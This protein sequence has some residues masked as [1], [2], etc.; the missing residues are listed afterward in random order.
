MRGWLGIRADDSMWCGQRGTVGNAK[1]PTIS[2]ATQRLIVTV[3]T[4]ATHHFQP[5]IAPPWYTIHKSVFLSGGDG[6]GG[7]NCN[8]RR[9]PRSLVVPGDSRVMCNLAHR[10]SCSAFCFIPEQHQAELL[11]T[12]FSCG[13]ST[14]LGL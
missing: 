9:R 13:P 5:H 7:I 6:A 11:T 3:G 8:A 4:I 12:T 2:S 10:L 1:P 14:F